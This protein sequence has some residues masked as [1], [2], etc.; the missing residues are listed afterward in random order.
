VRLRDDGGYE[1][2]WCGA[3][4]DIPIDAKIKSMISAASGRPTV[5][6]LRIGKIE[7]HR[8]EQRDDG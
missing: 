2:T 8:C 6:V 7:I 4:L 1:C 5:R 3:P